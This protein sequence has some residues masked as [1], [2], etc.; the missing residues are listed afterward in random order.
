MLAGNHRNTI[1]SH[2][3]IAQSVH[4]NRPVD[5]RAKLS[6]SC[7]SAGIM[8]GYCP[9]SA[10]CL[11]AEPPSPVLLYGNTIRKAGRRGGR[12]AGGGRGGGG[13]GGGA[14]AGVL[15]DGLAEDFYEEV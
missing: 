6:A 8:T 5:T 7:D 2:D 4:T 1:R 12:G 3:Q 15:S 10:I 9:K 11:V 13:G 14:G